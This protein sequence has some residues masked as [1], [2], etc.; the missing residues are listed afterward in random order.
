VRRSPE[1]LAVAPRARGGR[2][3]WLLL[4][5]GW[6]FFAL[7]AI[8]A[9]LPVLPTTPFLLL[10]LWAFSSS[11]ERF[12]AWL[13]HHRFFGPPLQRWRRERTLPRWVKGVAMTSMSASF[14]Y[15]ALAV[16]PAWYALAA[17]GG[18]MLS[19]VV[20]LARIPSR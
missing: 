6:I 18:V 9:V 17:V 20:Y 10:A 19:G 5:L 16:R 15:L 11:S 7:G 12:H 14:L 13:Y 3:R 4:A 1:P 2:W 8:G